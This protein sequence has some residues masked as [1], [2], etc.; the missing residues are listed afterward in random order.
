MPAVDA[1][2]G[3]RTASFFA[4][5]YVRASL[6]RRGACAANPPATPSLRIS[7]GFQ[8]CRRFIALFSRR[9][10]IPL[11]SGGQAFVKRFAEGG[12]DCAAAFDV[13]RSAGLFEQAGQL[14]RK[15]TR[16]NS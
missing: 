13:H 2:T 1:R 5:A 4:A 15:S 6:T 11:G 14:D 3:A 8:L 7:T 9:F 16:L 10:H 12:F